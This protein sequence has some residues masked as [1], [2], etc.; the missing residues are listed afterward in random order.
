[1]RRG[2][3]L[4]RARGRYNYDA[5]LASIF[6]G[7][8]AGDDFHRLDR[9]EGDLIRKDLALLVGDR[10]AIDGKRI[11]RVIAESVK[12]AVGIGGDSRR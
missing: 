3:T 7:R 5:G 1:M 10:L 12:E 6:R 9:V 8:R 4:T 11:L 2:Y